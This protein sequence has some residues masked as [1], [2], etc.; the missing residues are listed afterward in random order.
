[1]VSYLFI[2]RWSRCGCP[3]K[4]ICKPGMGQLAEVLKIRPGEGR[5]VAVLVG[6]MSVI[7]AG[8]GMGA[9]SVD[10]LFFSRFGVQYLPY[11]Y[12]VLGLVTFLN[13]IAIT[14]LLGG[15]SPE[16]LYPF[17]PLVLGAA[18]ILSRLPIALGL[19]WFYPVLF[20]VK[21][22]IITLQSILMWGLAGAL[23]DT[24]Q[25]RRLFPL[26]MA[27]SIAGTTI[28]SMIT[29]LVVGALGA[30]NVLLVWAITLAAGY[31]L[32][33]LLPGFGKTGIRRGGGL[34]S[35]TRKRRRETGGNDFLKEIVRGYQFVRQSALMR[36]FSLASVLFSILWFSILLPFS[37]VAAQHY[38]NADQLASFLGLF[39]GLQSGIAL[40]VSLL[41]ANRLFVRF[42]LMNMLLVYSAIYL[43]GFGVLVGFASFPAIVIFRFIKLVWAQGIAST[44]WQ[45]GYNAIPS[46]RRGQAQAFISA[47]PGQAGIVLSGIILVISDRALPPPLLYWIGLA[48]A[49]LCCYVLWQTRQAYRQALVEALRLGQ[50]QV[51]YSEEEPFG[52][53]QRDATAVPIALNGLEDPHPGVRRLSAEILENLA[54]P[55]AEQALL[56]VVHDPDAEVRAAALRALAAANEDAAVRQALACL[57]D[58]HLEVRS[59]AIEVLARLGA[60]QPEVVGRIRSLGDDQQPS[61]RARAAVALARAG[62]TASVQAILSKMAADPGPET[63]ARAM[64]AAWESWRECESCRE[65]YLEILEAG[66]DDESS[67]VRRSVAE[68]MSVPPNE[69]VERLTRCLGDEDNSVRQAAAEALGRSGEPALEAILEAL[70]NPDFEGG[71]LRALDTLPL[72]A[73]GEAL[74]AC[75]NRNVSQAVRY[76]RVALDLTGNSNETAAGALSESAFAADE[77]TRLLCESLQAKARA[78]ALNALRAI[79]LLTDRRS[80]SL[81]IENLQSQD[82]AQRAYALEALEAIGEPQLVRSLIPIWESSETKVA[83]EDG[84][85][86]QVLSDEDAWLRACGALY[87]RGRKDP[88]THVLLTQLIQSDPDPL[89]RE[90]AAWAIGGGDGV[91][92]LQTIS[93][94]ERVLFLR[95]VKL[96]ANLAPVDLKQIAAVA[97]EHLFLDE[98]VIAHEGENGDEMYI[99]VSGEVRVLNEH[100]EELARRKPGDY[101]GEMA[102]INQQP[103]MATLIASG[104]VRT[105]C[106]G[107]KQFEGI[108]RERFEISLAVMREL[109]ERLKQ[110][111]TA[112][113]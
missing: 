79:G 100:G 96:F 80:V 5:L 72:A 8:S 10:A 93:T 64:Q 29:P 30:E 37:R 77:R 20:I 75:A 24:R 34:S 97:R 16:R 39:Q 88:Q 110:S 3:E 95:R 48:T 9:A 36:W 90:T 53:F 85:W 107:R 12:I 51:F 26:F 104:N 4:G 1:M 58:P 2:A 106:I 60:Q 111:S 54:A 68:A 49:V 31:A 50:P 105:L 38:P 55:Q 86:S 59:Q 42:G 82:S 112:R 66:L 7:S 69:L 18:L 28:G 14:G 102:I 57:D 63:R 6:M 74:R 15:V 11:L 44:A 94:M 45:A 33:R 47:V 98:E 78:H 99:I 84:L 21:E 35:Q 22:V 17:M 40:L 61:I 62:D 108:L 23:F 83:P 56:Q 65:L 103:R 32:I 89:V 27:G 46:E 71:A 70:K 81:S 19:R 43:A 73:P 76:H 92:T 109:C 52:G 25:A 13:L 113:V 91:D 101:V 67:L 41:L 87:A